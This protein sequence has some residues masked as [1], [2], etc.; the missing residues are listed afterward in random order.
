M[1]YGQVSCAPALARRG[2]INSPTPHSGRMDIQRSSQTKSAWLDRSCGKNKMIGGEHRRSA[3]EYRIPS[4]RMGNSRSSQ[5]KSAWLDRSCGESINMI[6]EEHRKPTTD[7][8]KPKNICFSVK[9]L[10]LCHKLL[11]SNPYISATQ[12]HRPLIFQTMNS[13]GSNNLSLKYHR[14]T[15]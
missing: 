6:V 10:S 13:V 3:T 11:F 8:R 4:G 15:P 9:D 7:Y 2:W 5:S 12:R 14:F 1:E